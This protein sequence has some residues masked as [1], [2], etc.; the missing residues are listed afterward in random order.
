LFFSDRKQALCFQT[1]DKATPK[2]AQACARQIHNRRFGGA[3]V[4]FF[5]AIIECDG[6]VDQSAP[7]EICHDDPD[8]VF[9]VRTEGSISESVCAFKGDCA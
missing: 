3:V 1:K 6:S 5:K 9:I 7:G 8:A 4:L 2:M